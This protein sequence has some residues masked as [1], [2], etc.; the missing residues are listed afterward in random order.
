MNRTPTK[1]IDLMFNSLKMSNGIFKK[2]YQQ[3]ER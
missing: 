2:I 3:E 1:C